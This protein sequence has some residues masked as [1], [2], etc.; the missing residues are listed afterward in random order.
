M[1]SRGDNSGSR[2]TVLERIGRGASDIRTGGGSSDEPEMDPRW[3]NVAVGK[4]G[5][6][7]MDGISGCSQRVA[8]LVSSPG[9]KPNLPRSALVLTAFASRSRAS[10]AA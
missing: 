8:H 9:R 2:F 10:L 1:K 7:V 4:G 5:S 3:L 6:L